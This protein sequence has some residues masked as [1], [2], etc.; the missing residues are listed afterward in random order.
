MCVC[1]RESKCISTRTQ[2]HVHVCTKH[3]LGT[4][5]TATRCNTLQHAATRCNMLQH[6]ATRCNTLQHAATRCNTLQHAATRCNTLQ[7]AATRCNTLQHAALQNIDYLRSLHM[8]VCV[9]VRIYLCIESEIYGP[10]RCM[11]VCMKKYSADCQKKMT[12]QIC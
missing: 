2:M 9:Y 3:R 5:H 6:D 4:R 1:V 8:Y 12:E 7:H 11:Q 10:E